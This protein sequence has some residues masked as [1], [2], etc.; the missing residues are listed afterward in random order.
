MTA[1]KAEASLGAWWC[2]QSPA[3]HMTRRGAQ[4]SRTVLVKL[5]G[6]STL[7]VES[8]YE[9]GRKKIHVHHLHS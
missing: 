3:G 8:P 6:F 4:Q 7:M 1:Q 9:Q 2:A 5:E